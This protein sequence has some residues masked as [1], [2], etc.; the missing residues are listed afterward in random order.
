MP[1]MSSVGIRI[2]IRFKGGGAIRYLQA[3]LTRVR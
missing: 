1:I 2:F 3:L